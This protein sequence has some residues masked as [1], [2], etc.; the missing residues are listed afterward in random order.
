VLTVLGIPLLGVGILLQMQLVVEPPY[1]T[2]HRDANE[3]DTRH[4]E[5]ILAF[6]WI[7]DILVGP[8]YLLFPTGS[9]PTGVQ[10]DGKDLEASR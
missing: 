8:L 4:L 9:K 2:L 7:C 6:P 10:A 5:E 1:L 3:I